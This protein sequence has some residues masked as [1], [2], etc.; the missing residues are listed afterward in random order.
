MGDL[1]YS[2]GVSLDGYVED[3]QGGFDWATPDDE[4]H[5]LANQQA[6]QASVFVFG[7]RMFETM[8][9]YWIQ[10]SEEEGLPPIETEF[11]AAY[12]ATPRYVVS[13]TLAIA[14]NGANVGS[15]CRRRTASGTP[16]GRVRDPRRDRWRGNCGVADRPY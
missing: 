1:I 8:D 12:A 6:H 2:M 13:D 14:N 15:T 5:S 16:Q 9:D 11:A 7:R 10:A 3:A 4:V